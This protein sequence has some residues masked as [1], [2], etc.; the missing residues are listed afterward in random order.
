VLNL[1][2]RLLDLPVLIIMPHFY[3]LNIHRVYFR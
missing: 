1:S 3:K 2:M